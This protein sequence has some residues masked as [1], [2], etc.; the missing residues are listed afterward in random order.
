VLM[1][2]GPLG[3]LV[4]RR[5]SAAQLRVARQR[6]PPVWRRG[7]NGELLIRGGAISLAGPQESA[8]PAFRCW[9]ATSA[10]PWRTVP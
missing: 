4:R 6:L 5:G 9:G 7:R 10:R 8:R 3:R 2:V 1:V